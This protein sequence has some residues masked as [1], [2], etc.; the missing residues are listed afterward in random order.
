MKSEK[1]ETATP[2]ADELGEQSAYQGPTEMQQQISRGDE[3]KG[4][5]NERDVVGAINPDD[6]PEEREDHDT[7]RRNS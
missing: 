3:T 6:M 2:T 7:T 1:S 5:P 4:D